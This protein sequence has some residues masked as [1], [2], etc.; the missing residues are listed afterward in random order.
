MLTVMTSSSLLGRRD[1]ER[2]CE[3][4]ATYYAH[5][6]LYIH[7]TS[8]TSGVIGGTISEFILKRVLRRERENKPDSRP[9]VRSAVTTAWTWLWNACCELVLLVAL[10]PENCSHLMCPVIHMTGRSMRSRV[11]TFT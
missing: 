11:T 7:G 5:R 1:R 6:S 10:T 2:A 4:A 3:R 9:V 8:G